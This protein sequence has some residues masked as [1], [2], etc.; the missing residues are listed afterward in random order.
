M[1]KQNSTGTPFSNFETEDYSLVVF[2]INQKLYDVC[3]DFDTFMNVT[4]SIIKDSY[5]L[6]ENHKTFAINIENVYDSNHANLKWKLYSYIGIFAEHFIPTVE[7]RKFYKPEELCVDKANYIGIEIS[8]ENKK[9][10]KL[11]FEGK[12]EKTELASL[13]YCSIDE[14]NE[15]LLKKCQFL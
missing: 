2:N 3:K 7:K 11:Y 12:L 15:I 1:N 6:L 8:E 5:R 4:L 13:L 10:I 14:I 9:N